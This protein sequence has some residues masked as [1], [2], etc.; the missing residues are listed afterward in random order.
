MDTHYL[1]S[2]IEPEPET[3]L[4]KGFFGTT[5]IHPDTYEWSKYYPIVN[6]GVIEQSPSEELKAFSNNVLKYR[7]VRD[8]AG[9]IC[10][11]TNNGDA[12]LEK[13][14]F[15]TMAG[16]SRRATIGSEI[17]DIEMAGTPRC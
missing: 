16:M 8:L 4:D 7:A 17:A 14:T 6:P 10:H 12:K 1:Y 15:Q 11:D 13:P 5:V 3:D 9:T 2:R